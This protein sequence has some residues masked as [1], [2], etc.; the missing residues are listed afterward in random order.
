MQAYFCGVSAPIF[1]FLISVSINLS[2]P[3]FAPLGCSFFF[4]HIHLF[5]FFTLAYILC[6]PSLPPSPFEAL[7]V[8]SG[9]ILFFFQLCDCD[10]SVFTSLHIFFSLIPSLSYPVSL[11][12]ITC[13]VC[14]LPRFLQQ[15]A[16]SGTSSALG[17]PRTPHRSHL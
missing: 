1:F 14:R 8:Y 15:S 7:M 17:V 5:L 10:P 11:I 2:F 16:Q 12:Y 6:M 4:C 3:F 13:A 9:P